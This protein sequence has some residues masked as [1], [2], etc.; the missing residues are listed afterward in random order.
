MPG[1]K[2]FQLVHLSLKEYLQQPRRFIFPAPLG[3]LL[4]P[5]LSFIVATLR[6]AIHS[7]YY[8]DLIIFVAIFLSLDEVLKSHRVAG[9]LFVRSL[10]FLMDKKAGLK[11][12][13]MENLVAKGALSAKKPMSVD[14]K[15]PPFG[16]YA[17]RFWAQHLYCLYE[18]DWTPQEEIRYGKSVLQFLK[19]HLLDWL[20]SLSLKDNLGDGVLSVKRLVQI[21][22]NLQGGNRELDPFLKDAERFMMQFFPIIERAPFQVYGSALAFCPNNSIVRSTFWDR[23][24]PFA[25]KIKSPHDDWSPILQALEGHK[26]D[27]TS[28]AFSKDGKLIASQSGPEKIHL[29]D[30]ETGRLKRM[31]GIE[32]GR[33]QIPTFSPRGQL[34]ASGQQSSANGERKN[35]IWVWDEQTGELL[36]SIDAALNLDTCSPNDDDPD[37]DDLA[38]LIR[39]LWPLDPI[40]CS[41]DGD[42]LAAV[43]PTS[44]QLWHLERIFDCFNV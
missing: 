3:L 30:T 35:M 15:L 23:V 6:A 37:D 21:F 17:C 4:L 39:W 13:A 12:E 8:L 24:L 16:R 2:T 28:V 19:T 14:A 7:F 27:I 9:D 44:I 11:R 32:N 38:A 18:V 5:Y 29:W 34:I 26:S 31:V 43:T 25:K 36:R 1:D 22:N 41:P 40:A 42:V 20:R 10:A 33:L